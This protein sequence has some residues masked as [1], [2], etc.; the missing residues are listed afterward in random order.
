MRSTEVRKLSE[1]K[2]CTHIC[3]QWWQLLAAHQI[4]H[5]KL[6][7]CLR[8]LRPSPDHTVWGRGNFDIQN[9]NHPGLLLGALAWLIQHVCVA[10]CR[11]KTFCLAELL[12]IIW[13]IWGEHSESF[14]RRNWTY[15]SWLYFVEKNTISSYLYTKFLSQ[16][17]GIFHKTCYKY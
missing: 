16:W 15:I 2:I 6:A 4:C 14:L 12:W 13:T 1:S 3:I 11:K 5:F 8:L 10:S 17:F 9:K 7:S